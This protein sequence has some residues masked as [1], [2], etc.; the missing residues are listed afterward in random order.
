MDHR[1]WTSDSILWAMG[2]LQ[3]CFQ[4]IVVYKMK[5]KSEAG[6]LLSIFEDFFFNFREK[7]EDIPSSVSPPG[8]AAG[9]GGV[10]A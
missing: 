6:H 9:R 2:S 1:V 8:K 3:F 4:Q 5:W 10:W 7:I